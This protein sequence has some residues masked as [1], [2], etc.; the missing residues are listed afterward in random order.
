MKKSRIN[1]KK[2]KECR[3]KKSSK[4]YY[5]NKIIKSI[6][7]NKNNN[8]NYLWF[9]LIYTLYYIRVG[10]IYIMMMNQVDYV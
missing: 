3:K 9:D 5:N 1:P 4:D 2:Q 7:N 8:N 10:L 6:S